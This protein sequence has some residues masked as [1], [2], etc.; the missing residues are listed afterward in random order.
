MVLSLDWK[1]VVEIDEIQLPEPANSQISSDEDKRSVS[2]P[3]QD[4]GEAPD[5]SIFHGRTDELATLEQWVLRDHCRLV[6]ILGI[7][8]IGK[9]TL[10]VKLGMGGIGKSTLSIKLAKQIQGEF[11]YV[12]W[13]SLLNA[14]PAEDILTDLIQFLSNQEEIDLPKSFSS[15]VLRLL[16]YLRQH[17]CLIILDNAESVLQGRERAGQYREGYENYGNLFKQ[18]GETFHQSCLLLTS[19]EKPQEISLLEGRDRSVRSLQL[20][21][22]DEL[23]GRKIF[24]ENGEFVASDSEWKELIEFYNGNPLALDIV[25]KHIKYTF[26]NNIPK[27]LEQ[28][29]QVF[30]DLRDILNWHFS[31]LSDT[32][33]ELMYWL[34]IN[35]EAVSIL[36]LQD[37]ILSQRN[38]EHIL[39]TLQM[40]ER[41]LP[42]ERIATGFTLQPVLI[43]YMTEQL[44]E[45]SYSEI[46][47]ERIDVIN[48][49]SWLKSLAKEY[50]RETQVRVILKPIQ[51]RLESHFGSQDRLKQNLEKIL[52]SL[53]E[54]SVQKAGYFA[55]NILNLL[56][57]TKIDLAECNFS[58]FS[59]WQA[60]LQGA[61]LCGVNFSYSDFK[62]VVFTQ[63]LG[64]IL[65]MEF[66]PDGQ[67]LAI[68]DADK[69]FLFQISDYQ[70]K[71]VFK[72]HTDWV[73][74]I[75]FSQNNQI[76]ASGSEDYTIRMW[77]IGTHQ[78]IKTLRGHT[79]R[80]WFIVF[81]PDGRTIISASDDNTTKLWDVDTGECL[82]TY[83][84]YGGRAWSLN[85]S[86]GHY[87]VAN[88]VN[89]K[90][91]KISNLTTGKI[92]GILEKA[93]EKEGLVVFNQ[94]GTMLASSNGST[95]KLWNIDGNQYSKTLTGHSGRVQTINF[96]PVSEILISGCSDGKIKLWDVHTGGCI[97]T[98]QGH[99]NG[100]DLCVFKPDGQVFATGGADQ[101]VKIWD[102]H[103][104]R[105]LSTFEG[106]TNLVWSVAF[107]PDGQT[108]AGSSE[109]RLIKFWS[110]E[111]GECLNTLQGHSN[112]AES[113]AFNSSGHILASGSKD[114]TIR[115]WD[116]H[117]GTCICVL[118][119]HTNQIKSVVF[120][121]NDQVIASASADHTV[122]IW[123]AVTGE[124][125]RT[126]QGHSDRVW[127]V[128]F[129]PSDHVLAS[130]STDNT[131]KVWDI[132]TGECLTTLQGHSNRVWSVAFSP[133]GQILVSASDDY[134]LKLWD[135]STNSCISTL[136]G[137]KDEVK[138]VAFSPDGQI[139]ASASI[140][141]TIKLWNISA[142]ECFITL[143]GHSNRV[144]SVAFS[145]DG[146]ILA[147]ASHD[148]TI[149]L[150]SIKTGECL[151]TIR[152]NRPYE[153]MNITGVTGLSSSQR[154]S[155]KNLGAVQ[156]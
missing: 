88:P 97:K 18:I 12:I 140:D 9:T 75:A 44:I 80:V 108:I 34:A 98:I 100:V 123:D 28:G 132:N 113:I 106:Y 143:Q 7:G 84:G 6:A 48:R 99:L 114:Q 138:S 54:T 147:S 33:K 25:S 78:C 68:A 62:K 87:I 58:H 142:G 85:F 77:N 137:H 150:W 109:D 130:T 69:I 112:L 45:K 22:L 92:F 129:H 111:S 110:V 46:L 73:R 90:D 155:L 153:G 156:N 53:R 64:N 141:H 17:R 24:Q 67:L 76:I 61:N 40:L 145:P 152:S 91:I 59:V 2:N 21:G 144:W 93:F 41:R 39:E 82:E 23:E 42:V 19:R 72:G 15:K 74:S 119:G 32:E 52:R 149:K 136:E 27:F 121:H 133:D 151:R 118:H 60:Y 135:I 81:S 70:L 154:T 13:R 30:G 122:R 128:A 4:W 107:S 131:I 43:E 57:Q 126:L 117:D 124:C 56:C 127:S 95:I 89:N 47:E 102:V 105:C 29:K 8:G 65:A 3:T 96:S 79:N 16:S 66:S 120:S 49:Y 148:E 20:G 55:G 86:T 26:Q 51:S 1:E 36:E 146:Q 125:L 31:R 10:A 5:I 101:I 37:D 50:I 139:I 71:Y 94:Q 38:R 63:T 104:G 14:P 116:V 83:E 115:L 35:R 134:T 103:T 11:E